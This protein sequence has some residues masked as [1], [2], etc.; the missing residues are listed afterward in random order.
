MHIKNLRNIKWS[1]MTLANKT[2]LANVK[3]NRLMIISLVLIIILLLF[4]QQIIDIPPRQLGPYIERRAAG[5]RPLVSDS[6]K[7]LGDWLVRQDRGSSPWAAVALPQLP[8]LG[9]PPPPTV[10][11]RDVA[12]LRAAMTAARPGDV[13]ELAP[14]RYVVDGAPLA[15]ARPGPVIVQARVAGS[16]TIAVRTAEGIA[17]TAPGWTF[18]NLDLVGACAVAGHCEHAFHVSGRAS[19]FVARHNTLADFNAHF[20][21][22]GQAGSFPD[23]G[24][25]FANRLLN[26]AERRTASPVTPI[27]LVAASGWRIHRN[28][29]A[30][31]IKAGGDRISYGAFAK[32]AGGGNH[33][34]DNTVVCEYR[35][36][37]RPGQRVG[38]S[39]GGGGTGGRYCRDGRCVVEQQGSVLRGNL[40]AS[41]SDD[42]IYLNGA[43]ASVVERNTLM[44][45][46]GITVRYA[47][48]SA[49]VSAN[50]VD[51][52][53]RSRDGGV[54]RADGNHTTAAA[55]LYL[56]RHPLR[57]DYEEAIGTA[58]AR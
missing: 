24:E 26:T 22:N 45:T 54:I 23:A 50:Q 43:A 51:G 49:T 13:I 42:G 30:D 39:L 20:K 25:L 32:G 27:D 1:E 53:I 40:V 36:H 7:A 57:S 3:L 14:G 31:F 2:L 38:L 58:S 48:A 41:C 18:Q 9:E 56:G 34:V 35:L 17:V 29:I 33:F 44:D 5:H 21:I 55:W 47:H 52:L 6:G 10:E 37:G 11:V 28:V 16:A 12:G 19:R 8:Q 15:A 46:G 4:Y